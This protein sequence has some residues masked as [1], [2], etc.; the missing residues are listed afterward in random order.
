MLDR[1]VTRCNRDLRSKMNEFGYDVKT[2]GVCESFIFQLFRKIFQGRDYLQGE[3]N[4]RLFDQ[5]IQ[6]ILN[7][8]NLK[9]EIEMIQE[10]NGI[11]LTA[12]DY[13]FL[14]ILGFFDEIKVLLEPRHHKRLLNKSL[15]QVHFEEVYNCLEPL[16]QRGCPGVAFIHTQ[17]GIKNFAESINY[18]SALE[19]A[20][21][22]VFMIAPELH[23]QVGIGL[24]ANKHRVG[25]AYDL[26]RRC[27]RIEDSNIF[28]NFIETDSNNL[29]F[30]LWQLLKETHQFLGFGLIVL[31]HEKFPLIQELIYR[32]SL[33]KAMEVHSIHPAITFRETVR[34][35]RLP[36]LAVR[37]NDLEMFTSILNLST[38]YLDQG[39][40]EGFTPLHFAAL[41]NRHTIISQYGKYADLNKL[42]KGG[43]AP[44][45]VAASHGSCNAVQALLNLGVLANT[46]DVDAWTPL[47]HAIFNTHLDLVELLIKNGAMANVKDKNGETPAHLLL[48]QPYED[49]NDMDEDN[50]DKVVL[51]RDY[52]NIIIML[53][54]NGADFTIQ[55]HAGD[56]PLSLAVENNHWDIVML[57]LGYTRGA[58]NIPLEVRKDLI[59]N[60]VILRKKFIYFIN[61]LS[62]E[63]LP[64][65]EELI[66]EIENKENLLGILLA[67]KGKTSLQEVSYFSKRNSDARERKRKEY[68]EAVLNAE[69]SI[70][71]RR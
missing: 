22:A 36:H 61:E 24:C 66:H 59:D 20:L 30:Y 42:N 23:H 68:L 49:F 50:H 64:L 54:K 27:W 12:R 6:I 1:L 33:V 38:G 55:N 26:P 60:T 29:P 31:V 70:S 19:K 56:S 67:D 37:E 8:P 51:E 21:L 69:H 4:R 39:D 7:T 46:L 43:L 45:H 11:H 63:N 44:I 10:K 34:G 32:L 16:S 3:E 47:H 57:M 15:Q 53:A 62:D 41:F 65:Q 25:L 14:N 58:S 28:P 5:F 9:I 40:Q 18:F 52:I 35:D 2:S 48:D 71:N 13:V 17:V